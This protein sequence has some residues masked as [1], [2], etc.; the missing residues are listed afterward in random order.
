MD[1]NHGLGPLEDS[2]A[3]WI[4]SFEIDALR[5]PRWLYG[6]HLQTSYAFLLRRSEAISYTREVLNTSDGDLIDIDLTKQHEGRPLIIACHG[7][8]GSSRSKYMRRLMSRGVREGFNGIALNHRTCGGRLAQTIR[9]YHYGF[10]DDLDQVV[11]HAAKQY[12]KQPIVVIGYS[13]G[14][15]IVANWLGRC[16]STMPSNV[17]GAATVSAPLIASRDSHCLDVGRRFYGKFFLRTMKRKAK[18]LVDQQ[19]VSDRDQL[20]LEAISKAR[21]MEEFETWY[22]APAHGF[23][24]LDSYYRGVSPASWINSIAIPT[25][26]LHAHDD[27]VISSGKLPIQQLGSIPK[28]CFTMTERGGHVGFVSRDQNQWLEDQLF[29]WF[30]ACVS[31]AKPTKKDNLQAGSSS[32]ATNVNKGVL[33]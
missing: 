22:T 8:E 7:L 31:H 27:P 24:D 4:H 2:A 25:L 5:P 6:P 26:I 21:T 20:D 14:G 1:R 33:C 28:V 17:C 32:D 29:R 12:P 3:S 30:R 9:T 16:A 10:I 18:L 15:S 13:L 23:D 19:A 11:H